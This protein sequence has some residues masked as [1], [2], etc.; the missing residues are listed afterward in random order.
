[1]R[2][3]RRITFARGPHTMVMVMHACLKGGELE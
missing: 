2:M 1:L 3:N